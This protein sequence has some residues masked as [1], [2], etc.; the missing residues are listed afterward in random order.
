MLWR[1][2]LERG[3]LRAASKAPEFP[4]W[5]VGSGATEYQ[6]EQQYKQEERKAEDCREVQQWSGTNPPLLSNLV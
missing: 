5:Q 1:G 4:L 6:R 2:R 3:R